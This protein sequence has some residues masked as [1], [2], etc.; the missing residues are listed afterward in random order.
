MLSPIANELYST[1]NYLLQYVLLRKLKIARV[2]TQTDSIE[3]TTMAKQPKPPIQIEES[4]ERDNDLPIEGDLDAL[5]QY[6]GD[7]EEDE[8]D[9]MIKKEVLVGFEEEAAKFEL[10]DINP[11]VRVQ[12]ISANTSFVLWLFDHVF[13]DLFDPQLRKIF[14]AMMKREGGGSLDGVK[15]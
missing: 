6:L 8:C 7:D 2:T 13:T 3:T 10:N 1:K 9:V 14:E 5:C 12:Y 4:L 11:E 15:E